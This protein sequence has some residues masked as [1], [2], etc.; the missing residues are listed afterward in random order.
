MI[1]E[2]DREQNRNLRKVRSNAKSANLATELN[3]AMSQ[4]QKTWEKYA[5]NIHRKR[6]LNS[7]NASISKEEFLVQK[8]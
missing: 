3:F 8:K 5:Q 7:S 4:I 6:G 1:Q 2:V